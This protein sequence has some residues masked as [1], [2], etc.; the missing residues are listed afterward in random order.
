V[1]K[2]FDSHTHLNFLENKFEIIKKCEE[3]NIKCC[4]VGVDIKSCNEVLELSKK[5]KNLYYSLGI[6]PQNAS[7][8]ANLI[9]TLLNKDKRCVAIGECG[10][11]YYYD[12]VDKEVQKNVFIKQI[13]LATKYKLPL[14][15]H[16]RDAYEDLYSILLKYHKNL[17]NILIHCFDTTSY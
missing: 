15:I 17:S 14:I 10:L 5:S 1:E 6:H 3:Q 11:D 9:E 4:I 2:Y 7:L 16:C 13:E 12:G 8:D